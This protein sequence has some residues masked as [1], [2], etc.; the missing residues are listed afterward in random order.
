MPLTSKNED[1]RKK[2]ARNKHLELVSIFLLSS[3][4]IVTVTVKILFDPLFWINK[5]SYI[6]LS[7][8]K[9]L[10][11]EEIRPGICKDHP[12]LFV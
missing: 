3:R 7:T 12:T 10:S 2:L 11:A 5:K 8:K 6:I 9:I 4:I 1:K